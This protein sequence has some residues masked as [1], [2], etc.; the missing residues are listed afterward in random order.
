MEFSGQAIESE[1]LPA[2]RARQMF[3]DAIVGI[4]YSQYGYDIFA[5]NKV[6]ETTE[7]EHLRELA[8]GWS[9]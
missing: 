1:A 4:A 7:R 3:T 8:A 2:D 5:A 6:I 9:A